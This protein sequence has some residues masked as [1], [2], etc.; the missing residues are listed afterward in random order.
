MPIEEGHGGSS[1]RKPPT[2]SKQSREVYRAARAKRM[3]IINRA[4]LV[5]F[6]IAAMIGGIGVYFMTQRHEAEL[7]FTFAY[8]DRVA[9]A[10]SIIAIEKGYLEDEGLAIIPRMF[11]SGPECTEALT[12][13][14]AEFGT[15]GDTTGIIVGARRGD[16]FKIVCS[17]GGGEHRHRIIVSRGSAINSFSDLEG[18]RIGVKK[19]TSTHGGLLLF[20]KKHGLKI[21]SAILDMSPSLQL[22]ALAA[23][24]LDAIVSS[25]PTPSQAEA[26]GYGHE[27]ATLGDLQNTYPIL[28]VVSSSFAEE[29]SGMIVRMLRALM[30]ATEF[31]KRNP[32][33][34]A[35]IQSRITGLDAAIIKKAMGFHYYDV[36]MNDETKRSLK[37]M[38]EFLRDIGR[39]RE[40]PKF[41]E[42]IDET[43]LKQIN[44]PIR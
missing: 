1:T 41:D 31:I 16:A 42:F 40:L 10:A 13:G 12:S 5:I 33:E 30:R 14:N 21:N 34:A 38:A 11:S 22:T 17:H 9:D 37:S 2:G 29:H 39:I 18:G 27:L 26:G 19:G 44:K 7:G 25:E 23:G 3:K 4:L 8:Q 24:E 43:Y 20:A 6:G 32:D 15:M 36:T 35:K 28:L